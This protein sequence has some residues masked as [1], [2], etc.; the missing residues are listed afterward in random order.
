M[1]ALSLFPYGGAYAQC[2][3]AFYTA[4]T[5]MGCIICL[6]HLRAAALVLM[7]VV[8]V[9]FTVYSSAFSAISC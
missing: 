5:T 8:L 3:V 6:M 1:W 4:Y 7:T 2:H 9:P